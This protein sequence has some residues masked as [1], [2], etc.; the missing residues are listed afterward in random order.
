MVKI[1]RR[2]GWR[3]RPVSSPS[4]YC[5]LLEKR[6]LAGERTRLRLAEMPALQPRFWVH[7]SPPDVQHVLQEPMLRR[8]GKRPSPVHCA[9]LLAPSASVVKPTRHALQGGAL[10]DALP[11]RDQVPAGHRAQ[12]ALA[13]LA[14]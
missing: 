11:P 13:L 1:V 4:S 3:G 10:T 9:L 6:P 5:Q 12:G 8:W 14:P 2:M 7:G